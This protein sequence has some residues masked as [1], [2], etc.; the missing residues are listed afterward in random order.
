ML[1]LCNLPFGGVSPVARWTFLPGYVLAGEWWR[2]I[3]FP[4][5]HVSGYHLLL[6]A[7]AFL[8]LYAMWEER[9][10]WRRVVL[11]GASCAGSLVGAACVAEFARLGLCGLSGAAHGLAALV[12]LESIR[13]ERRGRL[14]RLTGWAVLVAVVAKSV[15][16][17]VSGQVI[18]SGLHPGSVG[19]PNP[20]CHL[21][22][23]VG[24]LLAW[25]LVATRVPFVRQRATRT[26]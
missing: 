5:V 12:A 8:G 22:G 16:E 4:F 1:V 25:V 24:A 18:F 3:T 23:V 21:G 13:A 2:V 20:V 15:T 17:A 11:V 6:D 26:A 19:V 10:V 14:A 9:S 7:G